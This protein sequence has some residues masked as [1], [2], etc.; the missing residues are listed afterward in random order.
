MRQTMMRRWAALLAVVGMAVAVVAGAAGPASAGNGKDDYTHPTTLTRDQCEIYENF[1]KAGVPER[2][3]T[4]HRRSPRGKAYHVGV[5]YTYKGYALVLD[6]AKKGE[7]SWGFM[8]QSCLADPRAYD[9]QHHPLP[10]LWAVGGHHGQTKAVPISAYHRG[11]KKHGPIHTDSVG[12][13]RSA[14]RSFVIGNVRPGDPFYITT[15]ECG[16]RDP[17]GWVL[18]YAPQ[19]GRWGYVQAGHLPACR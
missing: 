5:R 4:K 19:S 12:S 11:K 8:A 6:Y 9:P 1:P 17:E 7:P 18:G 10:D 3:W 16:H 14:P 15:A 13:L 2:S